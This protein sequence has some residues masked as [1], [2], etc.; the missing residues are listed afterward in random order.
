MNFTTTCTMSSPEI[1]YSIRP[2]PGVRYVLK[3]PRMRSLQSRLEYLSRI[4]GARFRVGHRSLTACDLAQAEDAVRIQEARAAAEA[5]A[6][7]L[8]REREDW[9][10]DSRSSKNKRRE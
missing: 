3:P 6:A 7:R 10:G 8:A 1:W 4:V 5:D 9:S 2:W